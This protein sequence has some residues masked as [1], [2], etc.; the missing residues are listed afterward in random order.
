VVAGHDR[1]DICLLIFPNPSACRALAGLPQQAPIRESFAS[2]KVRD[3]IRAAIQDHNVK[4]SGASSMR[5]WRVLLLDAPPSIDANEITDKGY[6][7]QREVLTRRAEL[8][9]R[10]YA[11]PCHPEVVEIA[12]N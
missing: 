11:E 5:V 4:S 7:N 8:V 9:D 1:D 10:L 2:Q 6:I 3:A 12:A